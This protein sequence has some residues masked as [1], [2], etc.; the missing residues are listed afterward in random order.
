[1]VNVI[2]ILDICCRFYLRIRN[3]TKKRNTDTTTTSASSSRELVK[4]ESGKMCPPRD[5][6]PMVFARVWHGE[7]NAASNAIG[8]AIQYSRSHDAAIRVYD[9]AGN[10]IEM[11]EHE[12]DFKN[13]LATARSKKARCA[14]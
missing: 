4:P 12:G 7:P 6:R 2:F 14:A 9:E 8:Y 3:G 13:R 11:H 5:C 1:V 10:V